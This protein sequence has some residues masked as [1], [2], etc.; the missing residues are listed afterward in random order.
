MDLVF[1][2]V[3]K[4]NISKSTAGPHHNLRYL[5]LSKSTYVPLKKSTF[6]LNLKYLH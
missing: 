3:K 2:F 4:K 5:P 6:V 1:V